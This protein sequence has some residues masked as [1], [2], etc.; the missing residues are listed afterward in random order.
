[1]ILTNARVVTRTGVVHGGVELDGATIAAVEPLPRGEDL[2]GA[3]L[4]PGFVDLHNHGGGGYSFTTG[5]ADEAR[6]AAAFTC[7][8]APPRCWRAW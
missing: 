5:R 8:T 3:Y 6:D 7:G 1:V 2:G 4:V